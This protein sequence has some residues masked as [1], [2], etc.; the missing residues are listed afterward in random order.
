MVEGED[1]IGGAKTAEDNPG[2]GNIVRYPAG[3]SGLQSMP[4]YY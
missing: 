4:A 1:Y 2:L 3:Y